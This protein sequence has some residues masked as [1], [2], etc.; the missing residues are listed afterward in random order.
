L[1]LTNS[2]D[3]KTNKYCLFIYTVKNCCFLSTGIKKKGQYFA[4]SYVDANLDSRYI[5]CHTMTSLPK[6]MWIKKE[7]N[8]IKYS[9]AGM[10]FTKDGFE[11]SY[12]NDRFYVVCEVRM[13]S[14]KYIHLQ[15]LYIG[16][17]CYL[18]A[19]CLSTYSNSSQAGGVWRA[20]PSLPHLT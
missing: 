12:V 1:Q 19:S 11:D 5:S 20:G 3:H 14:I 18:N 10:A 13:A 17:T 9:Q 6:S 8:N 7:P 4:T 2:S 15:C 16:I